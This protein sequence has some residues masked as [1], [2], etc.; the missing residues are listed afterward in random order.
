MW[1]FAAAEQGA[2]TDICQKYTVPIERLLSG[3][4]VLF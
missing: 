3:F 2:S 4:L 1:P